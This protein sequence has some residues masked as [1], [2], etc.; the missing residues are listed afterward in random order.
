MVNEGFKSSIY[1][2]ITTDTTLHDLRVF[3]GFLYCNWI[4]K[5]MKK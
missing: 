3:Q 4:I 1:T 5:I 2:A